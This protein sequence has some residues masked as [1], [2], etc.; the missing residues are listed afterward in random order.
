MRILGRFVLIL[1]VLL[2]TF[3]PAA[4]RVIRMQTT[5]SSKDHFESRRDLSRIM[6]SHNGVQINRLEP[7]VLR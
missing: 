4:V 2:A 1:A 6:R 5:I 7:D 3:S